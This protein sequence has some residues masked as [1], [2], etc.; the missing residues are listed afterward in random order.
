LH[1]EPGCIKTQGGGGE[2]H[3]PND[4]ILQ[5]TLAKMEGLI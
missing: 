4:N 1:E 3:L 5:N 2:T